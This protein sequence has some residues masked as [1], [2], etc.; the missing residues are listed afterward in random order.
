[1]ATTTR[2]CLICN[3]EMLCERGNKLFCSRACHAKQHRMRS[4]L[5]YSNKEMIQH[6]KLKQQEGHTN[7]TTHE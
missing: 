7:A 3:A 4:K 2:F 5:G 6:L 1:M